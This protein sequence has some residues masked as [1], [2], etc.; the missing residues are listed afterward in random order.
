[1]TGT[2]GCDREEGLREE[3]GEGGCQL[4]R[5]SRD[6]ARC[7]SVKGVEDSV[8]HDCVRTAYSRGGM[9]CTLD[10]EGDLSLVSRPGRSDTSVTEKLSSHVAYS[11]EE[12]KEV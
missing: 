1:M 3:L 9:Y 12:F 4:G 5:K 10:P 7:A 11:I 8:S 2:Q 6:D